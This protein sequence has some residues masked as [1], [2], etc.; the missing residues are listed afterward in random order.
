MADYRVLPD[1]DYL[2]AG[3]QEELD[4]FLPNIAPGR[5]PAV[6]IIHG[7]G[8]C[9]QS[10][11]GK[12]E[13]SLAADLCS[14]GYACASIDYQLVD[15]KRPQA[16]RE[17][18]PRNLDDCRQAVRFLVEHADEFEL[19]PDA[20]GLIGGSAGGHLAALLAL[21]SRPSGNDASP[22]GAVQAA[23]C[24][25]PVGDIL[26]WYQQ[27]SRELLSIHAVELM[28]GGTP[29]QAPEAYAAFSPIE[30]A[31]P[32]SPPLLIAHGTADA[33]IPVTHSEHFQRRLQ[34]LGATSQLIIVPDAPHSFDLQP[35]QMD[36]RPA[37]FDFLA[38]HLRS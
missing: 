3:R 19:D 28:L 4:L 15:L 27:A 31:H 10:R 22:A 37:V 17:V 33:V 18:F 25:Y 5:S 21:T 29:Q 35:P 14:Q 36:L 32:G 16:A 8:W 7:G 13:Y 34:E 11:K 20:I 26:H 30:H 9:T 38:A 24:L 6:V 1:I 2:G 23:V 12:R